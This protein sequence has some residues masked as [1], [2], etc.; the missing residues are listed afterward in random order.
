M[1]SGKSLESAEVDTAL[2]CLRRLSYLFTDPIHPM[3]Q[4][5]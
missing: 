3:Y 5:F 2:L 1:K 4:V